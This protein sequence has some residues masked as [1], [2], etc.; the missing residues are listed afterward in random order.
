MATITRRKI[1]VRRGSEGP[2]HDPYGYT[3]ITVTTNGDVVTYHGGLGEWVRVNGVKVDD[4][5]LAV[6]LF[7]RHTGMSVEQAMRAYD[8]AH[9]HFDDPMGRPGDYE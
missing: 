3:E 1:S 6:M 5:S 8:R 7:E 9:P 4:D 2:R